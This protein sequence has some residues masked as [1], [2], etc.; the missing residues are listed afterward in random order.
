[1]GQHCRWR[2]TVGVAPSKD[3]CSAINTSAVDRV[4]DN[5]IDE[6]DILRARVRRPAAEIRQADPEL[7]TIASAD[8]MPKGQFEDGDSVGTDPRK[9]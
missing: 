5:G 2:Q 3:R 4:R 9:G 7:A 8:T 6:L 1:M